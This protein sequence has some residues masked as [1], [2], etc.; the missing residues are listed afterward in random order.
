MS[1]DIFLSYLQDALTTVLMVSAAPL[2]VAIVVGF[3]I[4]L[5]QALTQIQDQALP[6]AIKLIG[7]MVV[8]ILAG[9]LLAHPVVNLA[10][11]IFEHFPE[12]TR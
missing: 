3:S 4:G 10:A 7:I 12:W 6:Q 2:L 11:Q 1:S 5:L 9:P 8:L